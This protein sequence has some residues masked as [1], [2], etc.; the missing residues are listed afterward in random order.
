MATDTASLAHSQSER[1]KILVHTLLF[2][3]GFSFV[4]IVGWGGSAVLLILP[5]AIL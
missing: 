1:L 5:W 3:L 4:F 2:V